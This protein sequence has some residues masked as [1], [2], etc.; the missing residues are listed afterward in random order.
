MA[1]REGAAKPIFNCQWTQETT[2]EWARFASV[3]FDCFV[4]DHDRLASD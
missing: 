1:R 4:M 3:N 2:C